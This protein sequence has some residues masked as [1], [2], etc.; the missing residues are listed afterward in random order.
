MVDELINGLLNQ[1]SSFEK[2]IKKY[3][4]IIFLVESNWNKVL[5]NKRTESKLVFND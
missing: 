5:K 2:L 3:Q 4:I 1:K